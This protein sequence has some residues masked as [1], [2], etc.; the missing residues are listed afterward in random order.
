MSEYNEYFD[1]LASYGDLSELSLHTLGA[2]FW[3]HQEQKLTQE[4]QRREDAEKALETLKGAFITDNAFAI[5]DEHF[6]KYNTQK[7]GTSL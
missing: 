7:S 4:K 3:D 5:I 6:E 1:K 2:L